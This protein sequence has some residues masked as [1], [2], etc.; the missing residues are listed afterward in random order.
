M[1]YRV[2]WQ[3][4]TVHFSNDGTGAYNVSDDNVVFECEGSR[5]SMLL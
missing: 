1:P 5:V 3:K 4:K 2:Q